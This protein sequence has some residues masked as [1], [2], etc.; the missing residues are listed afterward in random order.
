MKP[1]FIPIETLPKSVNPESGFLIAANNQATVAS[2][3]VPGTARA[4]RISMR[5]GS[6]TRGNYHKLNIEDME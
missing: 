5:L 3:P 2:R 4:N 1:S 6:M